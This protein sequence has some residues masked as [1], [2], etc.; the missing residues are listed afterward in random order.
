MRCYLD[1]NILVFLLTGNTGELTADVRSVLE[2]FGNILL[3]SSECVHELMHLC[4][5]DRLEAGKSKQGLFHAGDI[6][7][8][9]P[10]PPRQLRPQVR[11]VR[12]VL[13]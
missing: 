6:L 3:T 11:M 4:Q 1:T 2:D 7:D 9:R 12:E 10:H 8:Q 13:P 5:I